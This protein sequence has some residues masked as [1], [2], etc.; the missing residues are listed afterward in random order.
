[1]YLALWFTLGSD[2]AALAAVLSLGE[3]FLIFLTA[4]SLAGLFSAIE[5]M[6]SAWA[7]SFRE[8]QTYLSPLSILVV[9]PGVLLQYV[10]PSGVSSLW[11]APSLGQW[12]AHL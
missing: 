9:L 8:A 5:L 7:R 1:M 4:L 6:I 2:F 12:P 3:I 11:Y 10:D